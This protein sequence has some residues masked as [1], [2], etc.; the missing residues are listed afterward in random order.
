MM[1]ALPGAMKRW[2]C[3]VVAAA[4]ALLAAFAAYQ[5]YVIHE[6]R[7]VR[8]L[9]D[10]LVSQNPAV[11]RQA[12]ESLRR[13]RGK[14]AARVLVEAT[15]WRED[16]EDEV[17]EAR[18]NALAPFLAGMGRP[19]VDAVIEAARGFERREHYVLRVLGGRAPQWLRARLE[20]EDYGGPYPPALHKAVVAI[21]LDAV[22]PLISCLSDRCINVALLGV[23]VLG[24]IG[25]A[26]AAEP[27]TAALDDSRPQVRTAAAEAL[28]KLGARLAA[29]KLIGRLDAKEH[30]YVKL[31]AIEALAVL[32]E[33]K[34]APALARLALAADKE[35]VQS[36]AALALVQVAPDVA[37]DTFLDGLKSDSV[38]VR[39]AAA[40][41]LGLTGRA[42]AI[43]PLA[44]ALGDAE[45][46]V[47]EAALRALGNCGE[48]AGASV[49][50][51]LQTGD[52]SMR[53]EATGIA[54]RLKPPG[55]FEALSA[56]LADADPSVRYRAV[57]ALGTLGDRRAT[58]VL[59]SI[60]TQ[61]SSTMRNCAIE[62]LAMLRDVRAVPALAAC[63]ENG[64]KRGIEEADW[65][66]ERSLAAV[67]LGGIGD[68]SALAALQKAAR[69]ADLAELAADYR[70]YAARGTWD[71]Q[72]LVLVALAAHGN[73]R[74]ATDLYYSWGNEG[75]LAATR[76]EAV[77]LWARMRGISLWWL[78]PS[79]DWPDWANDFSIPYSEALGVP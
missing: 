17:Q 5:A 19:A 30:N 43:A 51:A 78:Y 65:E 11:R 25:D 52:D 27:V 73:E 28:G 59:I 72:F 34:A 10:G 63:L 54:A 3:R 75:L 42:E 76:G 9:V 35:W 74:M 49:L 37:L 24:D 69:N 36:K 70:T 58:P 20:D 8:S 1:E 62:G 38:H 48:G 29:D 66:E 22:K 4:M 57:V 40:G 77:Q 56:S 50:R 46:R 2:R 60:L 71:G 6:E 18:A 79:G 41:G 7:A 47:R 23:E 21:G 61:E 32:N 16:E 31:A 33:K 12:E 45:W 67:A 26:R 68:G 53:A 64:S 14:I 15:A 44:A 55:A 13:H 39:E